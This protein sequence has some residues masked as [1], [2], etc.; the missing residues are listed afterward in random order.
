MPWSLFLPMLWMPRFVGLIPEDQRAMFKGC[1]LGMVVGFVLL[2]AM[3]C[4]IPRYVMPAQPVMAIMV[5]WVLSRHTEPIPSDRMWIWGVVGEFVLVAGVAVGAM[6]LFPL[7]AYAWVACVLAVVG[8]MLAVAWR[9]KLVGG[10]R[11]A[12]ATSLVAVVGMWLYFGFGVPIIISQDDDRPPARAINAI[13]PASEDTYI[14]KPVHW[15]FLYTIRQPL[16]YVLSPEQIGPDV[17]YMVVPTADN[18]TPG[19]ARPWP[20]AAER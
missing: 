20:S 8:A 17:R 13:V 1:R 7:N 3:P 18:D 15:A 9:D 12:V 6:F 19:L 10:V 11:M 14:F 4:A 5:G 2:A 16:R